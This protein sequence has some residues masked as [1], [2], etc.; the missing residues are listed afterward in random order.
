MEFWLPF[1]RRE[2]IN[3]LYQMSKKKKHFLRSGDGDQMFIST[4]NLRLL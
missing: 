2:L 3:G 4:E 1:E